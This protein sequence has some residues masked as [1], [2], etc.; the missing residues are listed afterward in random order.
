MGPPRRPGSRNKRKAPGN[1]RKESGS[2]RTKLSA[3]GSQTRLSDRYFQMSGG[4][5]APS[6]Q[7]ASIPRSI[8]GDYDNGSEI[9]DPNPPE[10]KNNVIEGHDLDHIRS[11]LGFRSR[12][13]S[14]EENIPPFNEWDQNAGP[15]RSAGAARNPAAEQNEDQRRIQ[16]INGDLDEDAA[17]EFAREQSMN[18]TTSINGDLDDDAAYEFARE[19]SILNPIPSIET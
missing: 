18:P 3:D 15:R 1:G 4:L 10:H 9:Y 19:A 14:G 17:Y 5:G 16:A 12:G 6:T 7:S 11:P 8:N 2:K 13:D